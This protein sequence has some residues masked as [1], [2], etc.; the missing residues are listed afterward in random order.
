MVIVHSLLLLPW[1]GMIFHQTFVQPA[2]MNPLSHWL[3]LIC[4]VLIM[5]VA[6]Y[7]NYFNFYLLTF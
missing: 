3:K 4:S 7:F 5:V 1:Y 6:V 2:A